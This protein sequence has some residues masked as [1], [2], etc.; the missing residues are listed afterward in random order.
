MNLTIQFFCYFQYKSSTALLQSHLSLLFPLAREAAGR[1]LTVLSL[2]PEVSTAARECLLQSAC[3]SML[4]KVV[5][6]LLLLPVSLICSLLGHLTALLPAV[7][8][9]VRLTAAVP[10]EE[11]TDGWQW[12]SDAEQACGL[13]V[14]RCL[15]GLLAGPPALAEETDT[16]RWLSSP[17]LSRGL[18][19]DGEQIGG[20]LSALLTC[21]TRDG[22]LTDEVSVGQLSRLLDTVSWWSDPERVALVAAIGFDKQEYVYEEL[23]E[24]GL[25]EGLEPAPEDLPRTAEL[26]CRLLLVTLLRHAG[27]DT[28]SCTARQV[29]VR[30]V[31]DLVTPLSHAGCDKGSV[32]HARRQDMEVIYETVYRVRHELMGHYAAESAAPRTDR[33]RH[34]TRTTTDEDDERKSA[35]ADGDDSAGEEETPSE[36]CRFESVCTAVARACLFLCLAVVGPDKMDSDSVRD[37]CSEVLQF[38]CH[39][40]GNRR[41]LGDRR[42][43][44]GAGLASTDPF[45]LLVAMQQQQQR[46]QSRLIGLTQVCEFLTPIAASPPTPT[47][48]PTSTTAEGGQ[49]TVTAPAAAVVDR[50]ITETVLL[51]QVYE[52]FVAGCFGLSAV[53]PAPPVCRV[54]YYTDDVTAS[55]R[56]LRQR[57]QAVMA[58]IYRL[59]VAAL[60]EHQNGG[61]VRYRLEL[62][63]VL[64][65]SVEH[66]P[67]DVW[68]AADSGLLQLLSRL[69]EDSLWLT[70]VL[71]T[72][73]QPLAVASMRF[74]QILAVIA[75]VYAGSLPAT[76]CDEIVDLLRR[77]LAR[78][79]DACSR[80]E[81]ETAVITTVCDIAQPPPAAAGKHTR[82]SGAAPSASESTLDSVT[83]SS[84]DGDSELITSADESEYAERSA[85]DTAAPNTGKWSSSAGR[86]T[87][88]L[89]AARLTSTAQAAESSL[90]DLLVFVRHV[91]CTVSV[92]RLMTSRVWTGL[93]LRIC[94]QVPDGCGRQIQALRPRLLALQLLANVLPALDTRENREYAAQLVPELFHQLSDSLWLIPRAVAGLAASRKD[95]ELKRRLLRLSS[96]ECTSDGDGGENSIPVQDAGFDPDRCLFCTVENGQTLVHSQGGKGYGLGTTGIKSGCYQWRFLIVRETR[97]NE[98]TCVGVSRVPIR[99]YSHRTTNDMWL[100]RAYSHRTTNDMWLYRAYSRTLSFGKNGEQPRVVFEELDAAELYPCVMFYS[101]NPGE[102]VKLTDMQ[103]R[104]SPR[105]MLAGEPLCAPAAAVLLEA[106]IALIRTLHGTTGWTEHVNACLL[107]R[108]TK[109]KGLMPS[110]DTE[111]DLTETTGEESTAAGADTDPPSAVRRSASSDA[112]GRRRPAELTMT[113]I[114]EE[115][116]ESVGTDREPGGETEE[117]TPAGRRRRAVRQLCK[118]VLPALVVVAGVDRGLRV[119]GACV[120]RPS[121]RRAVVLGM[122][123]QGLSSVRLQWEDGDAAVSDAPVNSLEPCDPPP[124]NVSR[125]GHITADVIHQLVRLSGITDEVNLV[126]SPASD[127]SRSACDDPAPS[128]RG[129][130]E[131][132]SAG[133]SCGGG[134]GGAEETAPSAA[135]PARQSHSLVTMETLT[136]ELV[137]N[138]IGEVT[139][140]GGSR[141]R[142]G[143]SQPADTAASAAALH[144]L[145]RE[146]QAVRGCLLQ[147]SALKVLLVLLGDAGVTDLLYPPPDPSPADKKKELPAPDEAGQELRAELR[148]AVTHMVAAAI[149]SSP[150]RRLVSAAELERAVTVLHASHLRYQAEHGC[151]IRQTESQIAALLSSQPANAPAAFRADSGSSAPSDSAL[152]PSSLLSSVPIWWPQT[153]A[154]SRSAPPAATATA[155]GVTVTAA[156]PSPAASLST[157]R[158]RHPAGSGGAAAVRSPS[159]PPPPVALPL[160]EM[161]FSLRHIQRAI[162]VLGKLEK[163]KGRGEPG[164][165][166]DMSTHAVNQLASWMLE[167]PSIDD[168]STVS[169]PGPEPPASAGAAAAPCAA[170][171]AGASQQLMTHILDRHVAREMELSGGRSQDDTDTSDPLVEPSGGR[172][173]FRGQRS[174]PYADIRSF[175]GPSPGSSATDCSPFEYLARARGLSTNRDSQGQQAYPTQACAL[176]G[177][178]PCHCGTGASAGGRSGSVSGAAAAGRAAR[179]HWP[180]RRRSSDSRYVIDSEDEL[181]VLVERAVTEVG[182][183]ADRL[184]SD[185]DEANLELCDVCNAL[186]FNLTR[187]QRT[188]HPGCSRSW[189]NTYCGAVLVNPNV[190]E[191]LVR[192]TYVLC[193]LCTERYSA[194]TPAGR[195][196]SSQSV[197]ARPPPD[198]GATD[199]LTPSAGEQDDPESPAR[200]PPLSGDS[201]LLADSPLLASDRQRPDPVPFSESDPLGAGRVPLVAAE[202]GAGE[203]PEPPTGRHRSLAE[204]AA[205]LTASADRAAA[206]RQVARAGRVLLCRAAVMRVVQYVAA[207]GSERHL[208]ETLTAVGLGDI[209]LLVRLMC[210]TAAGRVQSTAES[211]SCRP[212]PAPSA[213]AGAGQLPAAASA[214]VRALSRA[215]GALAAAGDGAAAELVQLCTQD[216]M[217]AAVVPAPSGG[218][219]AAATNLAVTQ[220]LVELL[221]AGDILGKHGVPHKSPPSSPGGSSAGGGAPSLPPLCQLADALSACVLSMRATPALR[222]W[223]TQQLVRC[224]SVCQSSADPGD[225]SLCDLGGCLPRLPSREVQ[226]HGERVTQICWSKH[227]N[228][229][230]TCGCDGTVRLWSVPSS[231]VPVMEQTLVFHA[232]AGVFGPQLQSRQLGHLSWGDAG[233]LVAVCM[234][235]TLNVWTVPDAQLFI[236]DEPAWITAV[237]WPEPSGGQ[238]PALLLGRAD[239]RLVLVTVRRHGGEEEQHGPADVE[240]GRTELEH[241][242]SDNAVSVAH[243]SW[244]DGDSVFAVG[245]ADGSV[246]ISSPSPD[247][248]TR[249]LTVAQGLLTSVSLTADAALL[250][251]SGGDTAQVTVLAAPDSGGRRGDWLQLP[252]LPLEAPPVTLAWQAAGRGGAGP[253]QVLC[254]GC[255][256]GSTAVWLVRPTAEGCW[257]A[258]SSLRLRGHPS[259]PVTAVAPHSAGRPYLATGCFKGMIGLVNVWSLVDGALL[260]TVIGSG[261]LQSLAWV[262][263]AGIAACFARSKDVVTF[264]AVRPELRRL[265]PLATARAALIGRGVTALHQM[266]CLRHLLVL[267]PD[268]MAH[269]YAFEKPTVMAGDQLV[270]SGYLQALTC[271]ALGLRLDRVLCYTETAAHERQPQRVPEWSWLLNCSQA[272]HV[273]H[274]LLTRQPLPQLFVANQA[275]LDGDGG[276]REGGEPSPSATDNSQ[277]SVQQDGELMAWATHQPHDWQLGGGC[278]A[279][280]WGSGRHGQL[281]ESRSTFTPVRAESFGR[282]QSVVCGQNC[283]FVIQ[284]NGTVLACGEG[285]YGRLGQGNSDDLHALTVISGLQGFVVVQLTTS[286]GSDGH[287]LALAESGEVFSWGDGDY[288][289]LGHGNSDRQRRPRQIEALQSEE[290]VQV[291]CGFKHSAVV[292]ADGKLFTFGSGDYGRLG[293]GSTENKKLPERV[294]ALE[295]QRV[296]QVACG[297]NHTLAVSADGATVWSFGDG[298]HGK[299]GLGSTASKTTPQVV[300]AMSGLGVKKVLCGSQFSVFLTHCGSLYTCGIDRLIGQPDGR[301]RGHTRPQQV[302]ALRERTVVEVAVGAEHTLALTADGLVFAWGTNNDGQLGLGHTAGVREPQL[303]AALT[304]KHIRQISAGRCHSAAWTS[305]PIGPRTPGV[306]CGP[307]LG[308]PSRVPPQYGRLQGR[309]PAALRRRLLLLHRY[310]DLVYASWRLLPLTNA[311]PSEQLAPGLAAVTSPELRPLLAPR[312]YTLPMV[313]SLGRTMVQGKNY[314]PQITVKRLAV[315]SRACKPIFLQIARQ[316]VRLRPADLRLPSRA[317]KV[318]LIGEGADDAGG[319]FDDTITE[320]CVELTGGAV[321]LL[322]PTPN[323][324]SDTGCHRDRFLLNPE[325]AAPH[326]LSLFKFL[327]ILL[328]VA[329]RTKKPL[330]IPLAP[331]VW[332]LLANMSLGL[333]DLEETDSLFTQS[334]RYVRELSDDIPEETLNEVLPVETFEAPSCTGRLVPVVA[335][336]RTLRVTAA[337]RREYV[338]RAVLYR[339]HEMDLQVSAV[340]EG[341]SWMVPVPLLSLLTGQQLEQLVCGL[342]TISVPLLKTIV[343]YREL[344][345]QHPLAQ[346]LWAVLDSFSDSERVLFMRFV[347]GRSRLP[348]NLAD[349]S[350]RFQVMKVDKPT[351]GLP[352]AQTCFFQLRL[353]Q[354]S[355]QEMLADRLRYAIN[356]CRFIDMDS[357][358]LARN[359]DGGTVSDDEIM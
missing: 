308:V 12:L 127:T 94:G 203:R 288:G 179:R 78:L 268:L 214:G 340:R 329:I 346:W 1:A 32:Q 238:R 210:L 316:V 37:Q 61:E 350:Q 109:I 99:D 102:K 300:E 200:P 149:K 40:W 274:S 349:L 81:L 239:G 155:V 228:W 283:T 341:M 322:V 148:R 312:V 30:E 183:A 126:A 310:S 281:G 72:T 42:R 304:G 348:A 24:Y 266:Y 188:T 3:G 150:I 303:V 55:R 358:M 201:D 241:C 208:A 185:S 282:S 269:Q 60:F 273:A 152:A 97:G 36:R 117:A 140:R 48:A 323:A 7:D 79:L 254:A 195:R 121:S 284:S 250:A 249:T 85:T 159:P 56:Q 139:G 120:H 15:G 46:A 204:Q 307:S 4:S 76:T 342:P 314:G 339:L 263:A 65:L 151:R 251:V 175:L 161:G 6:S 93:L 44:A 293:L 39:D 63:G 227:R 184:Q 264:G 205:H 22:Q 280:L 233:A 327:G 335:G 83:A 218:T 311:Q 73:H 278:S 267:L 31:Y 225:E 96:P 275:S 170:P 25:A 26:V 58:D 142:A 222:T 196:N 192:T 100:Y 309:A 344:D 248:A 53:S 115:A 180:A 38:V 137:A 333:D 265:Q 235:S 253:E 285:S 231:G 206:L 168:V 134:G 28:A 186:V 345:E 80:P 67:E 223:A 90:G 297:L 337:T 256:D 326:Q 257:S 86:P 34:R 57:I 8:A 11:T 108:L 245:F 338:R 135:T 153:A 125:L 324:V 198:A 74:L 176:C 260:Q 68:R 244:P 171:V 173:T 270:H 16:A 289:K 261:G 103:L 252:P 144:Q 290:V 334:L 132:R 182:G 243:L 354:Y 128:G 298:D 219:A 138:I 318:K 357:Y 292:T 199:L 113:P 247:A 213:A 18:Q 111:A 147:M 194:Q 104:G 156:G 164:R 141:Q 110:T 166:G 271:L 87:A 107:E 240:Y 160:L 177:G 272:A 49:V 277:W 14:G 17:L 315:R 165:T 41:L 291:S 122:L 294:T 236:S 133:S 118:E 130:T 224:L 98:G 95:K 191:G 33:K 221:T 154:A 84:N 174:R 105:E 2:R 19:A 112:T 220:T 59:M 217:T 45:L 215:V 75:G 237:A 5:H 226:G 119:G 70:D 211:P 169:R 246:Q 52:Q 167:H 299:L 302:P 356:N 209:Q 91:A 343:R 320:M 158:Q 51:N 181:E 172:P 71:A 124:F 101:T 259:Y 29:S 234:E 106:H 163:E 328:G 88:V 207:S 232:A 187:H 295:D 54:R 129:V 47:A 351:D 359:T 50:P 197:G 62:I 20:C 82:Y 276:D 77:Q 64:S 331:F 92:R 317:W 69:S 193:D 313:R 66:R 145:T 306:S 13:L 10:G 43:P 325:L 242:G 143:R 355:S 301:I 146:E 229:M 216:L 352:T 9:L 114:V 35:A 202:P 296:G 305:P 123:K 287:S 212:P 286:A 258:E 230:A 131:S 336:G 178:Q 157:T 21:V 116:E 23:Y 319:V 189:L 89:Q 330:A 321:P 353:P 262:G 347:S 332:K 279:Y 255:V 162:S 190:P 27:C 136:D